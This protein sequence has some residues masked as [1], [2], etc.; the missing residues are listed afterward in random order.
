MPKMWSLNY[1][2]DMFVVYVGCYGDNL[3]MGYQPDRLPLLSRGWVLA[4]CHVRWVATDA[5]IWYPH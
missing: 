4:Y 5:F 3:Y 2:Y 1:Q